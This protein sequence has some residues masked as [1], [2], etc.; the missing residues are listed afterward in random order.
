MASGAAGPCVGWSPYL[1]AQVRELDE[2]RTRLEVLTEVH[3]SP[4]RPWWLPVT[5][6]LPST[7]NLEVRT[8]ETGPLLRRAG[9]LV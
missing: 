6:L 5:W 4:H 9:W 1:P 3:M 8:A 2:K 7:I